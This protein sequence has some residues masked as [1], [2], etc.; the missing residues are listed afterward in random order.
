MMI[1]YDK[2]GQVNWV[3]S[4]RQFLFSRGF[5]FVWNDQH[6]DSDDLFISQL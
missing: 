4:V 5:G 6:V 3:T 1:L 2:N